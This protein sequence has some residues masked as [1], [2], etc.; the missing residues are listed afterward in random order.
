VTRRSRQKRIVEGLRRHSGRIHF[1]TAVSLSL[2]ALVLLD[3]GL[4]NVASSRYPSGCSIGAI[5]GLCIERN[6]RAWGSLT[7]SVDDDFE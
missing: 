7:N 5:I 6:R 3:G 1:L 2:G 4:Y